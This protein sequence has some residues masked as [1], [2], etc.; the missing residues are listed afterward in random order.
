VREELRFIEQ[1]R[2]L[3]RAFPPAERDR[4]YQ[5]RFEPLGLLAPG[6]PYRDPDAGLAAAL[7]DR[8]AAGRRRLETAL[9]HA[10]SPNRTA[11]I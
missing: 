1:L 3:M 8:L 4:A 5:Q 11:G 10:P 2:A 7:R 6:S 9:T